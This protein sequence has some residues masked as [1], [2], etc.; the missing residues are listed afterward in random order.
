MYRRTICVFLFITSGFVIADEKV[1][2]E[3]NARSRLINEISNTQMRGIKVKPETLAK[4][5]VMAPAD[6]K[7]ALGLAAIYQDGLGEYEEESHESRQ[8]ELKWLTMAANSGCATAK[9]H[10][11]I[12]LSECR[13]LG[14]DKERA[15]RYLGKARDAH[16]TAAGWSLGDD[17][18]ESPE[19]TASPTEAVD[20]HFS[21]SVAQLRQIIDQQHTPDCWVV[22]DIDYVLCAPKDLLGRPKG[23]TLC[24]M[25]MRLDPRWNDEEPRRQLAECM[26]CEMEYELVDPDIPQLFINL[27]NRGIPTLA[28]TRISFDMKKVDAL[29]WRIRQLGEF[30]LVFDIQMDTNERF[31]I[32]EEGNLGAYRHHVIRS[33]KNQ[34]GDALGYFMDFIKKG[35]PKKLIFIDNNRQYLESVRRTCT[36]R[37]IEFCGIQFVSEKFERDAKPNIQTIAKQLEILTSRGKFIPYD[38]AARFNMQPL[39]PVC[40]MPEDEAILS[41]FAYATTH[42]AR[43]SCEAILEKVARGNYLAKAC[44][45]CLYHEGIG[46]VQ[47]DACLGRQYAYESAEYLEE[48]ADNKFVAYILARMF[49]QGIGVGSEKDKAEALL[50]ESKEQGNPKAAEAL[51]TDFIHTGKAPLTVLNDLNRTIQM[52]RELESMGNQRA[53]RELAVIMEKLK[54]IMPDMP[55][56]MFGVTIEWVKQP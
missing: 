5:K 39:M 33:G 35:E 22:S 11:G 43:E 25:L 32:G 28:L 26:M 42:H 2:H 13:I 14:K 9:F 30:G 36:K 20:I 40:S 34:K 53:R 52:L 1:N 27:K 10:L 18:F 12:R 15:S 4:L 45:A 8:E 56:I 23:Q 55:E 54:K 17:M 37:H 24:Q 51:E 7:I 29:D 3:Q 31:P 50:K 38:E 16:V 21:D 49:G 48:D 47:K 41:D 19:P 46:G 44:A 6:G